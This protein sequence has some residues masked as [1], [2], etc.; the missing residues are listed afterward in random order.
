MGVRSKALIT[1]GL[2]VVVVAAV[3]LQTQTDLLRGQLRLDT[4]REPLTEEEANL[5]NLEASLEAIESEDDVGNNVL[6]LDATIE[7]LGPGT[8]T[9][10]T[11]YTYALFVEGME[12][13]RNVDSYTSMNA[14]DS[15][16]FQYPVPQR[17]FEY[18]DSGTAEFVVDIANIIEEVDKT[19]NR[20][21]AAYLF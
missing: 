21:E 5:P 7:N 2:V 1:L 8:I 10:D 16:N 14:G 11:P 19:N 17:I 15:M 4:D 18:P 6:I 9:G 13:F 20:A 12:V 3:V